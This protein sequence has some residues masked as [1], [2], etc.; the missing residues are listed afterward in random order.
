M[1]VQ[2]DDFSHFGQD[3]ERYD[4][5]A[6]LGPDP[7]ET[8]VTEPVEVP[9]VDEGEVDA[10]PVAET[11]V[12]ETPVVEEDELPTGDL[13][14]KT[15]KRIQTLLEQRKAQDARIAALEAAIEQG[16]S[17]ATQMKA[18]TAIAEEMDIDISPDEVRKMFD[19]ALDNDLD[20]AVETFT[21][22]LQKVAGQSRRE[23]EAAQQR[24]A[25]QSQQQ[26]FD[27]TVTE[28]TA[29]YSIFDPQ[30][31]DYNNDLTMEVV[32]LRDMYVQQGQTMA[33]ALRKAAQRVL[34]SEGLWEDDSPAAPS[35]VAATT[36][37]VNK[38]A[39][40]SKMTAVR[41]PPT[42]A[43]AG[44][45]DKDGEQKAVDILKM[46]DAEFDALSDADLERLTGRKFS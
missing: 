12:T 21:K 40:A 13:K 44:R 22:M 43:K 27:T 6:H 37:D 5:L 46:T 35:T 3:R 10:P 30:A 34:K 1:T 14:A 32:A 25:Q 42:T 11:P 23:A 24:S 45:T 36:A 26:E 17:T 33:N 41:Q 7:D 29:A 39:L 16:K 38:K 9:D 15:Q 2:H 4:P 8:V 28:L 20:T 31:E 19:K 18:A